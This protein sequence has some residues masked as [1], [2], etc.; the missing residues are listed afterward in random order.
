MFAIE[1]NIQSSFLLCPQDDIILV[2]EVFYGFLF[3]FYFYSLSS[4]I[5]ATYQEAGYRTVV[6]LSKQSKDNFEQCW[7]LSIP[8]AQLVNTRR[9]VLQPSLQCKGQWW[10]SS[11]KAEA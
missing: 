5:V 6:S 9:T 7:K 10:P 3:F 11:A 1:S 2:I 8:G 4:D